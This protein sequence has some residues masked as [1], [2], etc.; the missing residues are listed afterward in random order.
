M[1]GKKL[2][3]T[4]V[5]MLCLI[6]LNA[7]EERGFGIKD[8]GLN[9]G[10]Y[11]P[12][13]DYWKNDSEFREADFEGAFEVKGYVEAFLAGGLNGRLGV[14]FWQ[15]NVEED[16]QGFGLTTWTLTGYPLSVD[17]LYFPNALRFSVISPYIG[18]G[19]EFLM[20]QQKLRFDQKENPNPVKGSSALFNGI[21]GFETKLSDQFSLDLEFN[22][23][24]GKY[25]QDF[26]VQEPNPDDP[27][28]PFTKM[29]TEDISL[30]GP[31]IGL[32]LK[33]LF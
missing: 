10:W 14:G 24:F 26:N 2:V 23:K 22:Y 32:T 21:F 8:V 6:S 20:L 17:L 4:I 30:T 27:E 25:S 31:K 11:N 1:I 12:S 3:A 9:L 13:L 33:Y 28:N 15:T 29:V 7:Q 19:G 16:L 5:L 18:A